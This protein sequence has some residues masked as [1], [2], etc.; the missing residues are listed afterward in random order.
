MMLVKKDILSFYDSVKELSI[1]SL[2]KERYED[3]V[4]YT[5]IAAEIAYRFNCDYFRQKSF[6]LIRKN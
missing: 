2:K 1:R 5:N 6:N 4:S 3:A